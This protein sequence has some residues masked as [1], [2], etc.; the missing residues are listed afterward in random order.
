[1]RINVPRPL[2]CTRKFISFC[3]AIDFIALGLHVIASQLYDVLEDRGLGI[4]GLVQ[5]EEV[6]IALH[7]DRTSFGDK[8]LARWLALR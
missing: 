2:Q 1:M 8:E 7:C 5:L 4:L 3:A 6:V